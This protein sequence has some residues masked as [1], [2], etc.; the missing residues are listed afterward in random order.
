M[1]KQTNPDDGIQA[2]GLKKIGLM[3]IGLILII[4]VFK[5]YTK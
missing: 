4:V 3:T 5:K 2:D 1:A